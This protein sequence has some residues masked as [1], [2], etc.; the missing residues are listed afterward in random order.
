MFASSLEAPRTVIRLPFASSYRRHC[1]PRLRSCRV[2]GG[3]RF[4]TQLTQDYDRV[5]QV[6][7]LG[8]KRINEW[9]GRQQHTQIATHASPLAGA[10]RWLAGANRMR[11]TSPFSCHTADSVALQ[12]R[13]PCFRAPATASMAAAGLTHPILAI[14]SAACHRSQQV[15]VNFNHLL[16]RLRGCR[17]NSTHTTRPHSR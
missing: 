6:G 2:Q 11:P 17:V 13:M 1:R 5:W 16:D 8:V 14:C 15:G 7:R 10:C 3:A 4:E 9:M 12:S